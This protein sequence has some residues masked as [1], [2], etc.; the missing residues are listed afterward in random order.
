MVCG[1][2]LAQA[3]RISCCTIEKG[4]IAAGTYVDDPLSTFAGSDEEIDRNVGQLVGML[5]AIGT[6]LRST[7]PNIPMRLSP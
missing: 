6:T 2:A 5:L 4:Q 1:R 3:M 7:K